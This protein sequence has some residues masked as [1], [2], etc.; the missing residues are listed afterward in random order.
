[1]TVVGPARVVALVGPTASGKSSV[2]LHAAEQLGAEIVAADA[3][4][5]YRGMDVATAKP[6]A[7][8]RSRVRHHMIDVLDPSK[9]CTVEWFQRAARAA[10]DR[11]HRT[12]RRALLV[13]GSGLYF[14]AVVDDL[15][16]PPTDE[17]TR[18]AVLARVGG[19]AEI[20]HAELQR[21]D[22]DAAARIEP[23][24]LRRSV[25]ALEVIELTG[26]PFSA[27]R[28]AWDEY[29]PWYPDLRV[30]GIDI[31][32]SDLDVRI[33]AR[34]EAMVA[35]GLVDE[36]R[37]LA[38]HGLSPTA[39]AAIGYRE[40]LDHL[41]RPPEERDRCALVEAIRTRTRQYAVRQ[42]RWF[43]RDPRIRWVPRG[44]AGQEVVG[45][46]SS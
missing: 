3:F 4:T 5:V 32:R 28:T 7:R 1:M 24:N 23:A 33:A 15:R 29:T 46:W 36:V 18:A 11:V 2:A 21:H 31:D 34:A 30:V 45:A 26:R 25:R 40:T 13:G 22:P 10:V 27:W 8:D 37:R 41:A 19:V 16:F 38:G 42:Q 39:R 9:T 14:R 17:A 44:A 35:G 12:G 6:S 43:A 20:A